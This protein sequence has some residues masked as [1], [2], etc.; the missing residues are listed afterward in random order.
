MSGKQI[1]MALAL[2][3][4]ALT[5]LPGLASAVLLETGAGAL[6]KEDPVVAFS[7]DFRLD[8]ESTDIECVESEVTGSV[9]ENGGEPA[10]VDLTT[11]SFTG[12]AGAKCTTSSGGLTAAVEANVAEGD[13][14]LETWVLE[15]G[16]VEV[17]GIGT[18]KPKSGATLSFKADLYLLG[19]K[20]ATCYYTA[21]E[22][23]VEYDFQT[24]LESPNGLDL[25]GTAVSKGAGSSGSCPEKGEVDGEF[26]VS[27]EAFAV[28]VAQAGIGFTPASLDF[29]G[30]PKNTVKAIK[31]V[32]QGT[33][34]LWLTT[35]WIEE[36]GKKTETDF[37]IVGVG[38]LQPCNLP[39]KGNPFQKLGINKDWCEI[40]VQFISGAAGKSAEYVVEIEG[41][42]RNSTARMKVSS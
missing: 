40:G 21:S 3:I 6:E 17:G 23:E 26:D 9:T 18:V 30:S 19:S 41:T 33:A 27:S 29:K 28:E 10:I 5:A 25:P 11:G 36:G 20:V 13:W 34:T 35:A 31:M 32:N 37:K 16:G 22:A 42:F 7:E 24:P 39:S 2:A 12:T 15:E 38:G 14:K 4:G 1:T 8:T